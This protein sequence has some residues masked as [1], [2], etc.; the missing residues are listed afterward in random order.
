MIDHD[1]HEKSDAFYIRKEEPVFIG[2]KNE[3]DDFQLGM[4]CVVKAKWAGK[5]VR[6]TSTVICRPVEEQETFK[7]RSNEVKD[8]IGGR[9]E[10]RS[11]T[12]PPDEVVTQSYCYFSN[13]DDF[14]TY[15]L[16]HE[17]QTML[18][19]N[20]KRQMPVKFECVIESDAFWGSSS[21]VLT[22]LITCAKV[23]DLP[24]ALTS[25]TSFSKSRTV[26]FNTF[27]RSQ[28]VGIPCS[29]SNERVVAYRITS[30]GDEAIVEDIRPSKEGNGMKM[31]LS[32]FTKRIR[33]P[34]VSVNGTV[35]CIDKESDYHFGKLG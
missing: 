8:V 23:E 6:L 13:T 22:N 10:S 29:D 9:K 19:S 34:T 3:T 33:F 27:Y 30:S 11:L 18:V 21:T 12:C 28:T 5:S 15:G 35:F 4:K 16:F 32:S 17:F 31:E 24:T 14:S 1:C 20:S 2:G 26:T 25:S 7:L